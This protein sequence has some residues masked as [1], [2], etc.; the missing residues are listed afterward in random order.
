MQFGA[1]TA[2][3]TLP[4]ERDLALVAGP[5][6]FATFVA[7]LVPGYSLVTTAHGDGY[8][9]KLRAMPAFVDGWID[10]LRQGASVGRAAT[11]RGVATA[12]ESFESLLRTE[13]VDDPLA[14]RR[15]T[16][17]AGSKSNSSVGMQNS[18]SERDSRSAT[19]ATSCSATA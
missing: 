10:G 11:A 6:N 3:A 17:S 5:F 13:L 2:A 14:W 7:A 9:T 16:W 4:F 1:G 12:L 19:F 8:I 15:D 18:N